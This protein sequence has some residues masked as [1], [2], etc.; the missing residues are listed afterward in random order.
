MSATL[1]VTEHQLTILDATGD[2]HQKWS[3]G[4]GAEVAAAKATFDALKA[5]GYV[6]FKVTG[7]G[8]KGEVIAAFDPALGEIIMTPPVIG[9]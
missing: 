8:G 4:N 1:T 2:T 3:P 5:K 6:A 9:G 7:A